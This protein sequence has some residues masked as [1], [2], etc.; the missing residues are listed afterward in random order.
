MQA[1]DTHQMMAFQ[2]DNQRPPHLL[3]GRHVGMAVVDE[4]TLLVV[5]G[6][7]ARLAVVRYCPGPDLY[8]VTVNSY[9]GEVED[10]DGV[11]CDMLGDLIFGIDAVPASYPMVELVILDPVTGEETDRVQ[12]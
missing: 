1:N 12:L 4:T 9:G 5:V 8:S 7:T 3:P 11:Y 2:I 10:F 6:P